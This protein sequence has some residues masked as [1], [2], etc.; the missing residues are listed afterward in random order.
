VITLECR[1]RGAGCGKGR[2]PLDAFTRFNGSR[3]REPATGT[4]SQQDDANR[5]AGARI[6]QIRRANGLSQE[7]LALEA[8]I[9]QS[10]LSKVERGGPHFISWQKLFSLADA[11]GCVVEVNLTSKSDG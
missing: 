2:N 5:A 11:L 1:S 9:D 4:V 10:A 7:A 8:S 3:N 6:R